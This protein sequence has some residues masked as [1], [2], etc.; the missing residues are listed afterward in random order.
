MIANTCCVKDRLKP[1]SIKIILLIFNTAC[2]LVING[3]LFNEAYVMKILRRRTKNFYFFIVDSTT[4]IVYSS[5]IGVVINIIVGL[6]FRADKQLR[7]VQSKY[8]DN[9][10]IL[11]GEIV[12]IYKSTKLLYIIFTIFNVFAMLIFMY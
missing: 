3:F 4:R 8:K 10:I 1:F 2:Y 6:L 12:R 7:K 5:L 9:K 11:N